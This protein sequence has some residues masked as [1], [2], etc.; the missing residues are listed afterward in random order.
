MS[1]LALAAPVEDKPAVAVA[2]DAVDRAALS[3]NVPALGLRGC[4]GQRT[5]CWNW[6]QLDVN[7]WT[8]PVTD[9]LPGQGLRPLGAGP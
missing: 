5:G 1:R 7:G 4:L 2:H 8:A 6:L 3:A 9:A